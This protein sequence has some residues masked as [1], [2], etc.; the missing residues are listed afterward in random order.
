MYKSR[1]F[2]FMDVLDLQGEKLGYI[3]DILIN[4]SK[5]EVIGFK[6]TPYKLFR[7]N[8]SILKEDIIYFNGAMV[9][10]KIT[11]EEYL[12]FS[13]IK[14]MYVID[15]NSKILGIVKELIFDGESFEIRAI[16]IAYSLVTSIFK[17]RR[18][19]LIKDMILG[20]DNLLYVGC[21][22]KYSFHCIPHNNFLHIGEDNIEG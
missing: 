2:V 3:K 8:F 17:E 18:I 6:V 16:S 19:L 15:K 4:F 11:K 22:D 10:N 20:K 1:D 9:I 21:Q 13:D 7:K 12:A 5:R 14:K